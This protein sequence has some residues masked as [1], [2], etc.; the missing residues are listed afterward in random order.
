MA[1]PEELFGLVFE[2]KFLSDGHSIKSANDA[3]Y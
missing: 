1:K 3:A 2:K